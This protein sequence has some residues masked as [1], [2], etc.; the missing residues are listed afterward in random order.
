[1]GRKAKFDGTVVSTG[2]GRKAKKQSDPTFPKGLIEKTSGPLS[3]HQKQRAKK[4]LL[5]KNQNEKLREPKAKKSKVSKEV[6]KREKIQSSADE[7]EEEED[8]DE[9]PVEET[10]EEEEQD[11]EEVEQNQSLGLK[12]GPADS[13]DADSSEEEEENEDQDDSDDDGDDDNL[14]PIEKANKRLKKKQEKERK[15]AE[16]EMKDIATHQDIFTFPTEEE[17]ANPTSLKDV[18][19]RIRDVIMVLSDF[20]TLRDKDRPRVDYM[21][22]LKADLCTYFSY[23]TFLMEK[24]MQIFPLS[25]LLEY[26]EASEVQRPMTLR[27]NTLKTRR[28][29][30]AQALINRGV[31]LDPIGKWTKIGLVVYS[32]QVPMGATPEYLAGHYILQGASSLLPVMALDPKENERILDMCAA[33]GGKASHIAALM[34]NTGVLFANDINQDRI[35]AVIGNFHRLGIV[36]SVICSYDGR[37]ISSAIKGFDRVLLDAPCTGTGVVAKDPGVKTNKD[38]VDVQRCCTLQRELLLAAIDC[39]NARSKTGGTIVYSTC[40]ILPEENEWIVDYAL[41]KRDVKVVPTGL[42][43]G[44]EGFTNY[45]QH[46]FHPSLKLTRR[47]YPH[48]HNMDGFFVAKLKK[49]SNIIPKKDTQKD[50]E[51]EEEEEEEKEKDSE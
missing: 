19:Q 12:S 14:L 27:T 22:L 11:N 20:K 13:D 48:V 50:E 3:R 43:F 42:E 4:R 16:D 1:M 25:E 8:A 18:Q 15:L 35:K 44:A 28:R 51:E 9:T 10:S 24:L 34:K 17:L 21:E 6:V 26:L 45:R 47:F 38:E 32:S 36:N 40:S 49:F 2:P 39:V 37:K 31:N 29:D 5:K 30:L 7:N 33:P 23:N 46:R 41:K